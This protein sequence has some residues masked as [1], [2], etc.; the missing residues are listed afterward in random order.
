MI[1]QILVTTLRDFYELGDKVKDVKTLEKFVEGHFDEP[2]H[3]LLEVR[4]EE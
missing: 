2:G 4:I 3:E 1:T